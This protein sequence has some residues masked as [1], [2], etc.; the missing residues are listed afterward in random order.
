[1]PLHPKSLILL[2]GTTID[3]VSSVWALLG[4]PLQ[5]PARLPP[6]RPSPCPHGDPP[7]S[8]SPPLNDDLLL[9]PLSLTTLSGCHHLQSKIEFCSMTPKALPNLAPAPF[10]VPSPVRCIFSERPHCPSSCHSCVFLETQFKYHL[11]CK[12]FS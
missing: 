6:S 8:L 4:C 3:Q 9:S 2:S 12:A 1:M 7:P 10:P 5:T 11:I